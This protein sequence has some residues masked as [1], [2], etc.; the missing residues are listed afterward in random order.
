METS[1]FMNHP[2]LYKSSRK[3][4][5]LASIAETGETHGLALSRVLGCSHS[6]VYPTLKEFLDAG[7]VERTD[8][9]AQEAAANDRAARANYR[10][11]HPGREALE[12]AQDHAKKTSP[13]V[14]SIANQV[15]HNDTRALEPHHRKLEPHPRLYPTRQQPP[16]NPFKPGIVNRLVVI[17]GPAAP[18]EPRNINFALMPCGSRY[19]PPT[20]SS[21]CRT[22]VIFPARTFECTSVHPAPTLLNRCTAVAN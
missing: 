13:F 16:A 5:I 11:T 10:I 3:R 8:E 4:D 14:R 17:P 1:Q 2:D 15:A 12:R 19:V 6:S 18:S 7:L 21:E 22:D 9:N 20:R